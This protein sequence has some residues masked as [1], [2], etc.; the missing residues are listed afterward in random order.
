M[1]K[2]KK[3]LVKRATLEVSQSLIYLKFYYRAVVTIQHGT[4][5]NQDQTC[6]AMELTRT[7]EINPATAAEVL[8]KV[9]KHTPSACLLL[10]NKC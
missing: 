7:P 3:Q 10:F 6:R 1:T 2:V 9:S 5:T 4:G 8:I